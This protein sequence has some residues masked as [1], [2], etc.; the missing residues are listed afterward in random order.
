MKYSQLPQKYKDL[1]NSAKNKRSFI[2]DSDD[3]ESRFILAFLP[4]SVDFWIQCCNAEQESELPTMYTYEDV[5]KDIAL[6]VGLFY[7]NKRYE[8]KTF[9]TT[10][11]E[12]YECAKHFV[13]TY[14]PDYNWEDDAMG[15]DDRVDEFIFN[16]LQTLKCI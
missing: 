10:F 8:T 16:N 11:D 13:D 6:F 15:Y 7:Y 9:L 12:V 4:M 3:I 1:A 14:P 2:Q 5:Q